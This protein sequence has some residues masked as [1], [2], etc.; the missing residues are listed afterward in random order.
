MQKN[1]FMYIWRKKAFLFLFYDNLMFNPF[2]REYKFACL[3]AF[4]VNGRF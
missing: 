4:K 2:Y 3:F 1:C